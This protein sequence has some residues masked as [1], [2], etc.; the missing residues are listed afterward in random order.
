[1]KYEIAN[2]IASMSTSIFATMGK[3]AIEH[4]AVNLG[5]GFPDF[6]GPSWLMDEA[7]GA[8]KS[9][10]NQYAP[11][12]GILSL[13]KQIAEVQNKYYGMDYDSETEITITAGATEALFAAIH[14]FI[15]PGDEVILF[16]P[17]YDAYQADV[18]HA[19]GVPK[20]ITLQKPDFSFDIEEIKKAISSKTKMMILNSPHNP[21]G[22]VFTNDELTSIAGL[23]IEH[24]F[25]ILS[26]EAYEFLTYDNAK[27]IPIATLPDMK[28]RTITVNSTG[29]TFGMTGW[30]IGYATA[31]QQ[32]TNAIRKVHQW[33]TFAVNTPM[34]HAMAHGFK[35]LDDYLPEFRNLYQAKRDKALELLSNTNF[36]PHIPLGSY[37]IMVDIPSGKFNDDVDAATRLVREF[38]VA[39]IPPSVFYSR[40]DEGKTMLRLCFAKS[41]ETLESGIKILENIV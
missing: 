19:G 1:M 2:R 8:M 37:F 22:K 32:I 38:G 30:K 4:Q 35:V 9:G 16:E 17:F 7:Y 24:D 34:Q 33:T 41:D 5:Q 21:T 3:M 36:Y 27:H 39:T 23:A 12:P 15:N 11:S 29:K 40:S 13:R 6:D 10:K 14:A 20:Y 31:T 26:D 28:K 18:I 25:L